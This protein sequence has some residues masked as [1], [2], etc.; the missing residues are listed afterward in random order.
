M[1]TPAPEGTET[2]VSRDDRHLVDQVRKLSIAD[3]RKWIDTAEGLQDEEL[4]H[5]MRDASNQLDALPDS[6]VEADPETSI[7]EAVEVTE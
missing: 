1:V 5:V 7:A 2:P 4:L 6:G 3:V